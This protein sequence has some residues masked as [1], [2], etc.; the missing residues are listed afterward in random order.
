MSNGLNQYTSVSGQNCCYDPNGNLTLDG[1]YVYL[2]DVENRLVE[3]RV[4]SNTTCTS[5][6]YAGQIKA[7][8]R[9]DPLGRLHEVEGF[10]GGVSQGKTRFLHDGNALVA[11]YDAS[12]A[13][14]K[15]YV[16]GPAAGTDDPILEYAGSGIGTS[17]RRNLYADARG[18]IVLGTSLKGTYPR[19]N[20]Y[21]EWG[22]PGS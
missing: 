16:H 2:Y 6:S 14:L 12:G 9:Y 17:V 3:M 7:K 21:D 8:L 1:Q 11:E 20:T 22:V 19:I 10:S 15:R 5:L 18:S 13:M 4:K